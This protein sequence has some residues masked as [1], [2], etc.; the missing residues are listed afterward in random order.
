MSQADLAVLAAMTDRLAALLGAGLPIADAWNALAEAGTDELAVDV[1]SVVERV[2]RSGGSV[3]EG[4]RLAA[5]FD[6]GRPVL[7]WLLRGKG[8]REPSV[9]GQFAE[10]LA[11]LATSWDLLDGCGAAP[12]GVLRAVAESLR[13]EREARAAIEVA[14]AGP[15]ATVW[16]LVAM[17]LAA[18]GFGQTLGADPLRVLLMTVPGRWALTL[19]CLLWGAGILW[20]R[21]ITR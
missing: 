6:G 7:G 10:G 5:R 2:L 14:A 11:W 4:L 18:L 20:A 19:G 13:A 8:A 15:K 21:R 9:G 16:V 12:A 17:P 1:A 3:S